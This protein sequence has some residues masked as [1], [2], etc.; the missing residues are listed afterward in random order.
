MTG[1]IARQGKASRASPPA[2]HAFVAAAINYLALVKMSFS[3]S[4]TCFEDTTVSGQLQVQMQ[5][6]ENGVAGRAVCRSCVSRAVHHPLS[7]EIHVACVCYALFTWDM[8][9]P[10]S[11]P[12]LTADA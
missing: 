9:C 5:E 2:L 6:R 8:R 10:G 3:F 1:V 4:L 12:P 11:I 7:R